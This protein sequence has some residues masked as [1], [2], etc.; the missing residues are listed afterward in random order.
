[1]KDIYF[2]ET[3]DSWINENPTTS[4]RG[5]VLSKNQNYIEISDENGFT[6]IININKIFA[7]VY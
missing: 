2:Y 4:I 1:M 3:M 6:Q 5:N 7:V